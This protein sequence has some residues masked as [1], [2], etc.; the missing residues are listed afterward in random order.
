MLDSRICSKIPDKNFAFTLQDITQ[1][2]FKEKVR[3]S[4]KRDFYF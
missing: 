2:D 4:Y 1:E 3:K